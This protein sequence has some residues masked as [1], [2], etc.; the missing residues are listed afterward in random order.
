MKVAQI[1]RGMVDESGMARLYELALFHEPLE[2]DGVESHDSR[3]GRVLETLFRSI[4][5]LL[6][7]ADNLSVPL[8]RG[9]RQE[10]TKVKEVVE[11]ASERI[12]TIA[13]IQP[14]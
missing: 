5:G 3:L 10:V 12:E 7:V 2:L 14:A 9:H 4:A 6:E 1:I 11:K 13:L 8:G